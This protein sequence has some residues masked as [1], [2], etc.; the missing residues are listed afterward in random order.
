MTIEYIKSIIDKTDNR[1]VNGNMERSRMCKK[2]TV[3]VNVLLR[4]RVVT[5]DTR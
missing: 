3:S 2:W 1:M 5:D 4:V